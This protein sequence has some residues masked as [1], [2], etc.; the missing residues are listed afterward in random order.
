MAG[1][2]HSAFASV[3]PLS[4]LEAL[5]MPKVSGWRSGYPR[6][7]RPRPETSFDPDCHRTVAVHSCDDG[8][9]SVWGVDII[10]SYG[11]RRGIIGAAPVV[12]L[13]PEGP[14]LIWLMNRSIRLRA[15][16]A[17]ALARS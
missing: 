3:H 17:T 16:S 12:N 4:W 13:V 10:N 11:H 6:F 15:C 2:V 14:R 5:E 8:L 7:G 9:L 1:F